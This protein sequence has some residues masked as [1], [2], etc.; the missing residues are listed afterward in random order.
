MTVLLKQGCLR[1][2]DLIFAAW[3]LVMIVDQ[4]DRHTSRIS[5][6]FSW[7]C[8]ASRGSGSA[9]INGGWSHSTGLC[10]TAAKFPLDSHGGGDCVGSNTPSPPIQYVW[11]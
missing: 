6:G 8:A 9:T 1:R 3:L 7:C 10:L 11:Y 4:Q 5:H 2:E